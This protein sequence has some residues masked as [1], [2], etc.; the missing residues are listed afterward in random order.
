M[1]NH[2]LFIRPVQSRI[3]LAL[4]MVVISVYGAWHNAKAEESLPSATP[5][6]PSVMRAH[7]DQLAKLESDK[8]ATNLFVSA[9]GP[10]LQMGD[11]ARTLGD[12]PL[13]AKLAKELLVPDL[14]AA[15]HR[16]IGSLAA[17]HLASTVRQA[18]RDQQ[19][20]T[21][22]ERLSGTT[23]SRAWLDQQGKASWHDSLNQL[24]DLV[25]SPEWAKGSQGESV[26]T[27]LVTVLERATQ[28]EVDALRASYQEWDRIRNW[29][30]RVRGIRGQAR[31]CGTWQWIIHNHQQHHQEQKL[32]LLFPPTGNMQ[33]TLPGLVETIVLGENVYLRWEID[34]R[35]QEDS[36]QFSKEGKGLEGTFVN[37]QGGWGSISGKRTAICTP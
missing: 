34:G 32:S 21:V 1:R 6:F 15:A 17:W 31:L 14:T 33:A 27:L 25:A 9:I 23:K 24:S 5:D 26:P 20:A 16:L 35:V 19:L 11:V 10:A 36:L 18:V 29:K 30:D 3:G 13:P 8:E 12:N 7:S 4:A 37:S 22:T 28:L 2:I